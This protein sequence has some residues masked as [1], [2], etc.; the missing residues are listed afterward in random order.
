MATIIIRSWKLYSIRVHSSSFDEP[1][2]EAL[3]N[4]NTPEEFGSAIT[5]LGPTTSDKHINVQYYALLREQAGRSDESIVTAAQ[6]PR[7]LYNELT[8]R[9]LFSLVPEMLR[10]AVNAEFGEWSTPLADGDS[11]VFIPPV[12]GG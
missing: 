8:S 9:Y 2:P 4:V 5:A 7:E 3:D 6:T 1:N 10:V 11:V 12:A